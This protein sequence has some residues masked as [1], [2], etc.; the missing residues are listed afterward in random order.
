M[1]GREDLESPARGTVSECSRLREQHER[2]EGSVWR[3]GD[4][5]S[6]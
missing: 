1:M 4:R 6:L 2:R 5:F 3:G